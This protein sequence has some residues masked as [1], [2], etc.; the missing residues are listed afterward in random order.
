M[1]VLYGRAVVVY[2]CGCTP[3]KIFLR[4][5]LQNRLPC[6]HP[7]TARRTPTDIYYLHLDQELHTAANT[8][9]TAAL[10]IAK[11]GGLNLQQKQ[12]NLLEIGQ[13]AKCLWAAANPRSSTTQWIPALLPGQRLSNRPCPGPAARCAGIAAAAAHAAEDNKEFIF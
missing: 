10:A 8:N 11:N 4:L 7:Q 13:P 12:H 9:Q 6:V 3:V 1:H 2:V 5:C